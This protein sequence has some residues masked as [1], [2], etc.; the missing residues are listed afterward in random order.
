MCGADRGCV[1]VANDVL[2]NWSINERLWQYQNKKANIF[3]IK[4]SIFW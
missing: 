2:Y 4:L 1:K 3:K